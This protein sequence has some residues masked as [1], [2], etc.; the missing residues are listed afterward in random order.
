VPSQVTIR[1]V[2]RYAG[3]S[4]T[5]VS[6]ILNNTPHRPVAEATRRRVLQAVETLGYHTNLNARRLA[7]DSSRLYGLVLSEI[8]NPFLADAIRAYETA[9]LEVGCDLLLAS[10]EYDSARAELAARKLIENQVLG[11]AVLTSKF[12]GTR[13]RHCENATSR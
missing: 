9:V 4:V 1:D 13:S 3:V 7:L 5:T 12:D 11:V 6:H 8:A 10:T 2:A